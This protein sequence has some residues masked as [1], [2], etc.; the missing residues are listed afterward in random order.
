MIR[1]V[2][3]R[4]PAHAF[5]PRLQPARPHLPGTQIGARPAVLV[6][7]FATVR[8]AVPNSVLAPHKMCGAPGSGAVPTAPVL[9][10]LLCLLSPPLAASSPHRRS[11]LHSIPTWPVTRLVT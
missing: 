7:L 8:A 1:L 11:P 9:P 3:C 4:T 5:A 2:A 10:S 6:G